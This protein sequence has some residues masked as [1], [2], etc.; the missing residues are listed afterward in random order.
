MAGEAAARGVPQIVSTDQVRNL[1][2]QLTAALDAVVRLIGVP[3]SKS[4]NTDA[5]GIATFAHGLGFTPSRV[6]AQ[7]RIGTIVAQAGL[8]VAVTAF[9]ATNMTI[10]CWM[11]D[12]TGLASGHYALIPAASVPYQID[13][14]AYR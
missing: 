4:G 9:D 10:R 5:S 11:G 7:S 13:F 3:G 1:P 12:S 6:F 14:M 2:S 8:V